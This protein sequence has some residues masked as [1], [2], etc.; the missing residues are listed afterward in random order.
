MRFTSPLFG[1]KNMEHTDEHNGRNKVRC[2]NDGL[3]KFL[4]SFAQHLI[5]HDCDNNW[6]REA[7]YKR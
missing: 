3:D 4:V 6:S 1:D 7:K 5:Q 2:I